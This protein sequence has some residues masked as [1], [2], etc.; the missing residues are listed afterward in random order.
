LN[1]RRKKAAQAEASFSLG[2]PALSND[3]IIVDELNERNSLPSK[4]KTSPIAHEKLLFTLE[5]L[6]MLKTQ[7]RQHVQVT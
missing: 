7:L 4:K 5:Q 6:E 1:A 3:P 2:F